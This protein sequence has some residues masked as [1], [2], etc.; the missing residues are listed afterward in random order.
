[1]RPKFQSKQSVIINASLEKVWE[2]GM[3][4]SKIPSYHPRVDKVDLISGKRFREPGVS[5]QCNLS[6]GKN[7]CV[8]KDI[9][10]IPMEKV[11]TIFLSDTMGLTEL[12]PDYIVETTVKKI[13]NHTTRVDISHFY[14][15]SKWKLRLLNIFIKWKVGKE[16][17]ETLESM[18][19]AI[20]N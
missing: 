9:E 18:K 8:E 4:L 3:D 15:N 14:S 10:I 20:E 6:D 16:T 12:L 1:M 7:T 5:Y 11:V 2:F 19:K 17:R 13:D